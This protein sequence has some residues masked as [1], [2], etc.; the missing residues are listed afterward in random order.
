MLCI[1]TGL[2]PE[3][4]S[5]VESLHGAQV[6]FS[7]RRTGSA[8]DLFDFRAIEG[9]NLESRSRLQLKAD[10]A[11]EPEEL[12]EVRVGTIELCLAPDEQL[13]RGGLIG[14]EHG[15][16]GAM[17]TFHAPTREELFVA[18]EDTHTGLAR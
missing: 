4:P 12:Q 16:C 5:P 17:A 15:C 9:L 10:S 8:G 7:T 18:I 2:A 14:G 3:M 6:R 11:E 13:G 1:A